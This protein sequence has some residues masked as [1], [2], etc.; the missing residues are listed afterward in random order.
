MHKSKRCGIMIKQPCEIIVF[1]LLPSIR[2]EL[3]KKLIEL[4]LTQQEVSQKLDMTP[5]AVSQ[6]VKGKRGT[7]VDFDEELQEDIKDLA[8]DIVDGSVESSAERICEI[9]SRAWDT[10]QIRIDEDLTNIPEKCGLCL[11]ERE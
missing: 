6:Y 5:A 7:A 10:Q 3:S 11:E 2:A 1:Y 9:C 8:E 4:G